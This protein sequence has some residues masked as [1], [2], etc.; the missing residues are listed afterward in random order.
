MEKDIIK[1]QGGINQIYRVSASCKT[2]Y[3]IAGG[4]QEQN[5]RVPAYRTE[6][7]KFFGCDK[8]KIIRV[9]QNKT[10]VFNFWGVPIN[11]TT[12]TSDKTL[13]KHANYRFY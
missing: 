7:F 6:T 4:Y 12:C 2:T 3:S 1:F 10:T 8:S 9:Q 5:N 11:E 13:L